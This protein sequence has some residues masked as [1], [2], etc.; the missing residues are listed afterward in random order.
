MT[1]ISAALSEDRK[2]V[3]VWERDKNK[4][5]T[6]RYDAPYEFYIKN[7]KGEYQDIHGEKLSKV[8]FNNA[9]EFF[10]TKKD[11]KERGIKLYES[12]INPIYKVLSEN[13]YGKDVG[14]LNFSLFDIEVD[15][16]PKRGFSSPEN[17]YAAVSAISIYHHHTDRMVLL[18]VLP[19]NG[20]WT[21]KDIPADL[22]D[23]S[24]ITVCKTEKELLLRFLDEIENSDIISGWNSAGFDVPYLYMRMLDRYGE[25]MANRLSFHNAPKPKTKEV[26]VFVGSKQLHVDI[27]GRVHIDYLEIFRKFET[28]TRPSFSLEAI[29]EE[30]MPE[31]SKLEYDGSLYSLYY[32][33]FP[34][35]CRYNVRDTEVLK[36]FEE[37]LGYMEIA[38]L[39]YHSS[40]AL[41]NDVLGTVKIVESAIINKCHHELNFKVP[42][43][44][45]PDY[46]MSN[47][48]FA[49]ALVLDP[50]VGMHDWVF[51]VDV[52]SL[53]P[54]AIRTLNISPEMII[55][56]FHSDF[57]AFEEITD[58]SSKNITLLLDNGDSE[59][60]PANQWPDVLRARQMCVSGY[61]TVFR[62]DMKG[63]IPSILEEWYRGRKIFKA[64]MK[65]AKDNMKKYPKGS[66]EYLKYDQEAAFYNRKQ[67]IMK[68]LLNSTYGCLG[69]KFF[70]FYDIRMAE[71]TTR[72][73]REALMHMVKTVAL[74]LDGEYTYPS[75]SCIYSDTD[76][77]YAIAPVDNLEDAV[78]VAKLIEK[79]VNNSFEIF[80]KEKFFCI[81]E[82]TDLIKAELDTIADRSIFVKK[83]FYIM[84]LLYADGSPSEKMKVM[85]LQIKK[86]T[87][88]K[89]ISKTLTDYLE[90]FLKGEQWRTIAKKVV[91]YKD[92]LINEQ[93][94][95]IGLPGGIKGVEDYT[96]RYNRNEPGLRV[97]GHVMAAIFYNKCLEVYGDKESPKIVSGMKIKKYYLTKKFDKFKSIAIPTDM[98][99][100]PPWFMEHF[101]PLIDRKAQLTRLVDNPLQSILTAIGEYA[102]TKKTVMVDDLFEY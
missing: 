71:S 22:H 54:S 27:F 84:H 69:N 81:G 15:Y 73:G 46:S 77:C 20:K 57:I 40:T 36:G 61:G 67:F 43:S 76:S 93:L 50:I 56:Q 74:H 5:V 37:K 24:D 33:N 59:T 78:R 102:P 95:N 3:N 39:N 18:V 72:S 58:R 75:P 2:H 48:K 29:S 13:Y 87:I 38:I 91:T 25:A 85:G 49:G 42:D 4:V 21:A 62:Q 19:D 83:K 30:I 86:T 79:K 8:Q 11:Y 9:F 53:Y 65:E 47:D 90:S 55:G 80:T 26:E 35:F 16:D 101:A 28:T 32:D 70:K 23:M 96:H 89:A 64:K 41:M 92:F 14:R 97:P 45:D 63:F 52:N 88:P 100:P 82:F 44:K 66:D 51:S 31:L 60:H 94:V 1:Y 7:K 68:L 99:A 12:D 6:K 10:N 34:H 98:K 17:P